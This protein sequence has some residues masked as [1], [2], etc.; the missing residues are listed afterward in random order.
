MAAGNLSGVRALL[1][2]LMYASPD[3]HLVG[4]RERIFLEFRRRVLGE[5]GVDPETL[6]ASSD[7]GFP[8]REDTKTR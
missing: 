3:P 1:K 2:E 8:L 7:P 4:E 5:I 6:D